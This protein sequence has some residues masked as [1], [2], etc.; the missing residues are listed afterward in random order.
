MVAALFSSLKDPFLLPSLT[1]KFLKFMR[2]ASHGIVQ[3]LA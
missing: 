3:K 1:A 2:K